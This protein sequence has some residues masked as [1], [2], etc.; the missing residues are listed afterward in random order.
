MDFELENGSPLSLPSC[1]CGSLLSYGKD[2]NEREL[3]LKMFPYLRFVSNEKICSAFTTTPVLDVYFFKADECCR[4]H[5]FP[6]Q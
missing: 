4:L 5:I 2:E 6:S 3:A 1:L